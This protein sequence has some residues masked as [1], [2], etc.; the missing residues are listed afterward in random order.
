MASP[1]HLTWAI[2]AAFPAEKLAEYAG[3]LPSTEV[4]RGSEKYSALVNSLPGSE[5]IDQTLAERISAARPKSEVF[6]LRFREDLE[7]VW[8]YKKG[9]RVRERPDDPWKLSRD[10][11]CV[12]R[13][14]APP[15]GVTSSV[16]VVIGRTPEQVAKA[17]GFKEVPD[18][19]VMH[20]R[21][22]PSGTYFYSEKGNVA[23]FID[24]VASALDVRV[25]LLSARNGG[26]EFS[27]SVLENGKDVGVYEIPVF[28]SAPLPQL[29][30]ID[31]KTAPAEIANALHV[32]PEV[33]GLERGEN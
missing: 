9:I 23:V 21:P 8:V 5:G 24:D 27:C 13:E 33:L 16:C 22:C 29:Q 12:L 18:S 14:E 31:G 15:S 4:V 2:L 20:I 6:L 11:G 26:A 30:S 25:Y 28:R 19:E 10:L 17:L 32:P 1:S 3:D 7:V